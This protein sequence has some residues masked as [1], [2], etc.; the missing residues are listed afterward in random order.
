MLET[1]T[2]PPTDGWIRIALDKTA[3]GLQ[4][5]AVPGQEQEYTL[6]LE[7]TFFVE[8]LRCQ[9]ACDPDGYNPLRFRGRV[10]AA[11]GRRAVKVAE[12]AEAGDKPLPRQPKPKK[13][14]EDEE[15]GEDEENAY[16]Q[17]SDLTLEDAGFV[18]GP[19]RSYAIT[20]DRSLAATDGQVLG[21]SWAG[22]VENW[23]QNAFTSFGS[24]HG[25]WE[26]SG[27]SQLPFSAR[28]L[29]A[30]KE[31][32][33]PMTLDGLM[34]A[35]KTL[36]EKNFSLSPPGAGTL[37]ALSPAADTIQAFGLGLKPILG[38]GGTGLGW[39]ALEESRTLPR[40]H[41]AEE[42]KVRATLVQVT[43]L[44]ITVKDSPSNTLVLVTR[45][46]DGQPVSG[47]QVTIRTLANTVAWSGVTGEDGLALAPE[48]PTLRD[49]EN[50]WE[51]RFLVT[52][53]KDGDTAYVGS[54]WGEGIEPWAFGI[55]LD[56]GEAHPLLRGTVWSDRGVYKLGEEVHVKAILRSDTAKGILAL[57][58][59]TAMEVVLKDS[60]GEE[61]DKRTVA[62]S[63]WSSADFALTLPAEAPL[64]RYELTATVAGQK[65]SVSGGFLVAAYR[66]P[67]FRVDVN[68]AGE[69]SRAGTT[70]KGVVAGRYLFGAPMAARPV[71]W[72]YTKKPRVDAPRVIAEKFP[73]ERYVLLDEE[74]EDRFE[75]HAD[76]AVA[77]KEATLD[78]QG[79]WTLDLET[80]RAAGRPFD[81]TLEGEVTDLSRQTIAGRASFRVD[82]A[83]WY[84]AV[85]RPGYFVDAAK[86]FDTDVSAADLAGKPTAGV[87]VTVTLTRVQWHAVRRAEGQGYYTWESERRETEAGSWEVTTT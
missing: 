14:E 17:T 30:V 23:H 61:R 28:N 77:G 5:K 81:Y 15:P 7:P 87:P 25:V 10:N 69:S 12:V 34:P 51:F 27:G 83:P 84:L 44:G 8:G 56:L 55:G 73:E 22:L 75:Y 67:D 66:R 31:W 52:A 64:G 62:L 40:T 63:D 78:A 6:K 74:R 33:A 38:A 80:D 48:T 57:P 85:R 70:L 13:T 20:V 42:K 41:R 76:E 49:P 59:G 18:L 16:D 29:V 60:Q 36:R 1:T 32:L 35:I 39:A 65:Q 4:G 54:D 47:A 86:G 68:L 26:K 19:A 82:P 79:Q 24:G 46:S 45:L 2:V 53:E 9:S 50:E 58:A 21:Y 37:R 11:T 43:D 3:V 71:K 72:S